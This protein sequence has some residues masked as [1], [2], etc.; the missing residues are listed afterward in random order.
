RSPLVG[1]EA[2]GPRASRRRPHRD[3][4]P[5][6]DRTPRERRLRRVLVDVRALDRP[7]RRV[8]VVSADSTDHTK[9]AERRRRLAAGACGG[10]AGALGF[11]C[12][13]QLLATGHHTS[14][15]NFWW[16]LNT[17]PYL[18]GLLVSSNVHQANPTA[19]FVVGVAQWLTI[20]FLLGLALRSILRT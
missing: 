11:V 13:D 5:R 20:G 2:V 4:R 1:P 3:P 14:F 19:Y 6:D 10:L 7:P 16:K 9:Q 18:A 15:T 17:I 8:D 12:V